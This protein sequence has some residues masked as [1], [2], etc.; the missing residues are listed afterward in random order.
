MGRANRAKPKKPKTITLKKN[1]VEK[2]KKQATADAIK[3]TGA[4]ALAVMVQNHGLTEDE[5]FKDMEDI[6]HWAQAM[7][8]HLVSISDMVPNA[9][10]Y[11][12]ETWQEKIGDT[13]NYLLILSAMVK[14]NA[15]G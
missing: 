7:D 1:E 2:I 4:L 13:I 14:E 3:I 12:P 10:N 9:K 8:K 5:V 15:D 6:G 11:P